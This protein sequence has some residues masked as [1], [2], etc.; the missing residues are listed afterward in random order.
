MRAARAV[1][2]NW[3]PAGLSG[4]GEIGWGGAMGFAPPLADFGRPG[5]EA[6]VWIAAFFSFAMLLLVD[7][8]L[9]VLSGGVSTAVVSLYV[10][11][12]IAI[13]AARPRALIAGLKEGW[14]LFL[15]PIFALMSTAWSGYPSATFKS[16]SEY[17]L[18][19]LT[20]VA[21]ASCVRPKTLL[22]A[23]LTSLAL[24]VAVSAAFNVERATNVGLFGSK[25]NF[26]LAVATLLPVGWAV[27]A[28][29]R[30][31]GAFRLLGAAA[32]IGAP[33]LLL[34]SDSTGALICSLATA[35]AVCGA[36]AL[37][38]LTPMARI[39]T[40]ALLTCAV[41]IPAVTWLAGGDLD[42]VLNAV[43]K[44]STLTGRT[45]LWSAAE[46]SI[47]AHPTLGVGY[48]AYWQLGSWGAEQLWKLSYVANKTGYHFHDTYLQVSVDLGL[49]GLAIFLVTLLAMLARIARALVFSR[50]APE[51]M[52][53]IYVVV[54]M[55]LRSPIEVDLF[56]QFQIPTIVFCMAWIY[57]VAAP[58]PASSWSESRLRRPLRPPARHDFG[59]TGQ[60]AWSQPQPRTALRLEWLTQVESRGEDVRGRR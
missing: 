48:Q 55:L 29:R 31:P 23:L 6:A 14:P 52:F 34:Q 60:N 18:T 10:A 9:S 35:A 32:V 47:A 24:V 1:V 39:G 49:V 56:W 16:A 22:S 17:L 58:A 27:A 51:A 57:L 50:M 53:A 19:T 46:A 2:G 4:G 37:S 3:R 12:W 40:L 8:T 5:A 42:Q 13:A 20:A 33:P 54:L 26:G 25:N 7:W 15:L 38:R 45:T 59:G 21:A 44:D 43:G 30:Q 36:L 11:P 28:D 41:A